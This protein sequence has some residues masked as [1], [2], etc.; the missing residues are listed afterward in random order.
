[1]CIIAFKTLRLFISRKKSAGEKKG[2]VFHCGR[3]ERAPG[4]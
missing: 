1:M 3:N 4:F 2:K